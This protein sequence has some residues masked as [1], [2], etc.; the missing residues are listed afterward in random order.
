MVQT[1]VSV[2][3]LTETIEVAIGL[4]EADKIA[5]AIKH[6][7]LAQKNK[8]TSGKRVPS[9][10]NL[11]MSERIKGLTDV[12]HKERMAKLSGMWKNLS[13]NEKEQYLNA[14]KRLKESASSEM[15]DK[16]DM[17]EDEKV[18]ESEKEEKEDK[19][20]KK[21]SKKDKVSN[22]KQ[23]KETKETKPNKKPK[24]QVVESE[25]ESSDSE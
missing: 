12:P 8:K 25:S 11:F 7:K 23:T 16:V 20:E 22:K 1:K 2:A 19:K 13:D 6:L 24:K 18:S 3:K 9:A 4:L 17:S 5:L 14:N 15:S 10:Y 21:T